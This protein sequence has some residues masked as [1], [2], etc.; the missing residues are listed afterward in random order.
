M[1]FWVGEHIEV[2]TSWYTQRDLEDLCL[3][4]PPYLALCIASIW[5]FLHNKSVN[6]NEVL[7]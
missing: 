2:L 3:P 4:H 6:L 1:S 5:L 7:P